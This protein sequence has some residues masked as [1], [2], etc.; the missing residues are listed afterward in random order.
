MAP[1]VPA[2]STAGSLEEAALVSFEGRLYKHLESPEAS[3]PIQT[4]S[5]EPQGPCLT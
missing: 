2:I 5:Q 1:E 4:S 3:P